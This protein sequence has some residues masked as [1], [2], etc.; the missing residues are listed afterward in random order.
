MQ[1]DVNKIK[2][3]EICSVFVCGPGHFRK[4]GPWIYGKNGPYTKI[5]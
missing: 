4:N 2:F 1:N 5:H 3:G